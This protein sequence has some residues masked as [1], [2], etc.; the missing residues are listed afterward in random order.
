MKPNDKPQQT[1]DAYEDPKLFI[2][3]G[4]EKVE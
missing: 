2:V 1:N 4:N 3:I